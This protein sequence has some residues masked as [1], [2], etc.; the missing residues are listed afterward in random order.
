MLTNWFSAISLIVSRFLSIQR[1]IQPR[2]RSTG[3]LVIDFLSSRISSDKNSL[4]MEN[5]TSRAF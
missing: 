2:S 4:K 3:D 1:F 5:T